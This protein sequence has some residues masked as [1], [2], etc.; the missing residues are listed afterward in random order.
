MSQSTSF[1][2]NGCNRAGCP[3]SDTASNL[4]SMALSNPNRL[5]TRFIS[6]TEGT[7]AP[8]SDATL[9]ASRDFP[10][11][12]RNMQDRRW[13]RELDNCIRVL[14]VVMKPINRQPPGLFPP[15]K[16]E[17]EIS[18]CLA[19]L[20]ENNHSARGRAPRRRTTSA[21][22]GSRDASRFAP[23]G[24]P[25]T[26]LARLWRQA[27]VGTTAEKTYPSGPARSGTM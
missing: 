5:P 25:N 4:P 12:K 3:A 2:I 11:R 7:I 9:R 24:N 22:S 15:A 26:S 16:T 27:R 21:T 19:V 13:G 18:F 17:D 20:D 8:A 14:C 23:P 10:L 6:K 1:P